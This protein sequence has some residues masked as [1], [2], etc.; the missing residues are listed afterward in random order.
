MFKSNY[1]NLS[2]LNAISQMNVP[3]FK[4]D[5]KSRSSTIFIPEK[6]L[7]FC[8]EPFK[9]RTVCEYPSW[10]CIQW[11]SEIWLVRI[12]NG[13]KEVGLVQILNGIWNPEA[14]LFEICTNGSHFVKYHLKPDHQKVR[15]S[16]FSR[17][18]MVEFQIP[19]ECELWLYILFIYSFEKWN[20]LHFDPQSCLRL[21]LSIAAKRSTSS[22]L[23]NGSLMSYKKIVNKC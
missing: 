10:N 14:Q 11:G 23:K 18:Q 7:P 16:N 21:K 19:T 4:W 5:L 8:H 12:L 9:I 13:Q 22:C 15:I 20:G 6:L 3:D 2:T 1:N 17:F